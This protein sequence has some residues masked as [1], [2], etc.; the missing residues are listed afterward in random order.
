MELGS[1]NLRMSSLSFSQYIPSF[2]GISAERSMTNWRTT[3]EKLLNESTVDCL[4]LMCRAFT[5][6]KQIKIMNKNTKK[7]HDME[8]IPQTGFF[9]N[10]SQT[11]D[12]MRHVRFATSG[13]F[14]LNQFSLFQFFVGHQLM[15]EGNLV[16]QPTAKLLSKLGVLAIEMAY[17]TNVSVSLDR[18]EV[19]VLVKMLEARMAHCEMER[20][21]RDTL[22]VDDNRAYASQEDAERN[23]K[24]NPDTYIAQK[25]L[26]LEMKEWLFGEILD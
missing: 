25:L 16:P 4:T 13:T 10:D 20:D 24:F 23:Q 12:G 22:E 5:G 3:K 18:R 1:G 19:T 2:S 21:R 8:N 17:P 15:D 14:T 26:L 9:A 11:E 7:Q 6:T